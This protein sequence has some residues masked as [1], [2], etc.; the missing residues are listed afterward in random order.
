M[1]SVIA[2]GIFFNSYKDYLTDRYIQKIAP[3]EL[4][5]AMRSKNRLG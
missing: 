5:A 4:V 3:T 2:K 1:V